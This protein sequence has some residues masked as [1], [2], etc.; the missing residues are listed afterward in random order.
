MNYIIVGDIHGCYQ[1]LRE[2]LI[3]FGYKFKKD[4]VTLIPKDTFLISCGDIV[5]RGPASE[6]KSRR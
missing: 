1:E 5:D 4:K 3:L 6:K 2:L